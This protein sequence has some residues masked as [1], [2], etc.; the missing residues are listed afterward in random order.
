MDQQ[1][2]PQ[3]Q[4][5]TQNTKL[6]SA[7]IVI[8]LVFGIGYI[9]LTKYSGLEKNNEE[10]TTNPN[11]GPMVVVENTPGVDGSLPVPAGFPQDIPIEQ[12]GISE[13]ATTNYPDQ[14][15]KQLSVSYKSS[16]TITQ[17]YAEYKTYLTQAGYG[18]TEGG[19]NTPVRAIFGTKDSANLSVAISSSGGKTLV[20]ISYLLK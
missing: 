17:K 16:K 5:E 10:A 2:Q 1:Q 3:T 9:L 14:N 11:Q 13:S 12:V 7:T 8:L 18:L 20:Q 19:A 6:I 15:A 4:P